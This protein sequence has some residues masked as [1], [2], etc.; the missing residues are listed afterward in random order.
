MASMAPVAPLVASASTNSLP[1][2]NWNQMSDS[3]RKILYQVY[4]NQGFCFETR[5]QLSDFLQNNFTLAEPG[6]MLACELATQLLE[7]MESYMKGLPR[8]S[9]FVTIKS[10][11]RQTLKNLKEKHSSTDDG[12]LDL[13]KIVHTSLMQEKELVYK[14]ANGPYKEIKEKTSTLIAKVEEIE[15]EKYKIEQEE[16]RKATEDYEIQE[17]ELNLNR[18]LKNGPEYKPGRI[19]RPS[20]YANNKDINDPKK[21][22]ETLR[23]NSDLKEKALQNGKAKLIQM[24]LNVLVDYRQVQKTVLE[25]LQLW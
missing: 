16:E 13:Y 17:M 15:D 5:L 8:R 3:T 21:K 1:W 9:T 12:K 2:P 20:P 18:S 22:L 11:M 23:K 7:E 14:H 10:T 24:I 19:R 25:N 6:K 4:K